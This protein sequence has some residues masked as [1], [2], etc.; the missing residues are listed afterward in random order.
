MEVQRVMLTKRK[1]VALPP[2]ERSLLLL[3][4][5]ASNEINVLSK[6]ILMVM[7]KDAPPFLIADHVETGQLCVLLRV[8]AGKLHEAW[9]L[10]K[11]RVQ[12]DRPLAE[13]YLPQL[14]AD[15]AAAL[16]RLNKHFGSQSPLTEIR[17]KIAF[18]Y[19]DN[20][21]LIEHSLQSIAETEPLEFYLTKL[22]G[23]SFYQASEQVIMSTAIKLA[24]S[25]TNCDEA[26]AFS[27]LCG[28]VIV[29]SRDITDLFGQL[30]GTIAATCPDLEVQIEN[31]PDGPKLSTLSLPYFIDFD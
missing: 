18:H 4:G 3:L 25:E 31:V 1:L 17:N 27:K 13:K 11:K 9:E 15:G 10:F 29:V 23:N 5:Q 26:Q 7:R 16:D 21:N 22:A 28:A 6:L 19:K 2:A 12:A 20:D 30:I 8:L 14:D 24:V